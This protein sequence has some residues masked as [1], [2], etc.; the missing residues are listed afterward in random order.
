V[1]DTTGRH[2]R[3]E[4]ALDT[5]RKPHGLHH[6]K[7]YID[8]QDITNDVIAIDW[9]ADATSAPTATIQIYAPGLQAEALETDTTP[10]ELITAPADPR[11]DELT[12]D[13]ATLREQLAGAFNQLHQLIIQTALACATCFTEE[14]QGTRAGHNLANTIIDGTAYC[15]EHLDD[16]NGRLV[17]RKSSGLIIAGG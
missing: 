16:V 10:G 2:V 17:P 13:V 15:N 1:T 8:D 3:I 7:I 9:H 4:S 14:R 12:N 5:N 6:T 11:L